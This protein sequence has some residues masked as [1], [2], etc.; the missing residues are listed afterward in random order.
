VSENGYTPAILHLPARQLVT[1]DWVMNNTQS[2]ARSV[3]I[4]GLDY[5]KILPTTGRVKLEIPAQEKGTVLR[6]TCSMGMYP[7][8]FVFDLDPVASQ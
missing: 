1:V 5:Q 4:P 3:V 2:C 7:S 8:Q 6:Y